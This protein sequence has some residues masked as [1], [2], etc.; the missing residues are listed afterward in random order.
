MIN[1]YMFTSES[2]TEGHPDKLCDQIS[3]AVVDHF[4]SLDPN[5]MV[6]CESAVSGAIIFIAAR[7]ASTITADFSLL[8]R[9]VIKRIGYDQPD[10]NAENCSILTAPRAL[11][12]DENHRFDERSLTDAQIDKIPSRNQVTVFGF[13]VDESPV[14]MP[15]PIYLANRLTQKLA[16]ARKTALLPYLMPDSKVQ[17]GVA[18]KDKV[19]CRIHSITL[20][21][22][23]RHPNKPGT[24]SL[25]QDF[26][27]TIVQPVFKNLKVRPD[28]KT[29]VNTNPNGP[30]LAGP[31]HHSGLTGRKIAVDTYGEYARH[32]GKAL[33]GKDPLRV[34]R[35]GAYA[36]RYAAKNIVAAGLA[37]T[38]EVMVSYATGIALPVSLIVNTF[39]S[40]VKSDQE[41]TEIV[42][43]RF[44]F[45]PAGILKAFQLRH[46]PARHPDGFFQ[47]LSAYGHFGR[48]DLG[49]PWEMTDM[50]DQL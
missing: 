6:R 32:S 21:V 43:D 25:K 7:F 29:M 41:L 33:S 35:T 24:Q 15:L 42:R 38:C 5:S 4:L 46:L 48:E 17:V 12:I 2:V 47:R 8:T 14:L 18:Y 30:Y 1:D 22:H 45:R 23:T 16:E 36:A 37:K 11:A 27:E 13:A 20:E 39:G 50:A 40:G 31:S 44:E 3:D 49:L 26:M 28:E 34:D 19:P 9:K 10:F